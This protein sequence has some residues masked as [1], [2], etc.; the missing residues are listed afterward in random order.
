MLNPRFIQERKP[1]IAIVGPTAIGKSRVAIE[2]AKALKTEVLTADSRQVYLGMDIGTDKPTEDER[3]GVP[4]RLIDLV[5]PDR[6]FTA[7]DYR[8]QARIE[9]ARL[10]REGRIPLVA[11]G[12]GL[13]IRVLFRGLCSG[14]PADWSVRQRLIREAEQQ[15]WE[16]L[17][18]QLACVD[19][20]L[21]RQLH[22]HDHV[23][24]QR[25]LEVYQLT[26]RP[27]S[28]AHRDHGFQD[29]AYSVLMIG[30]T[31]PRP[32]L[33]ARIEE[34]VERELG[35]GLVEETR[36]LLSKGY[37]RELPSM[38][39]LGYRQIAGFLHGEYSY[40]EA[41]RRLKRDTRHFA[42]RQYTWFRKEPAMRWMS[43]GADETPQ[44]IAGRILE[45]VERFVRTDDTRPSIPNGPQPLTPTMPHAF[46]LDS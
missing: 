13:Y 2:V 11:G 4:H 21:A 30:L 7:G 43:I 8:Q 33:Y 16:F 39:S 27:L 6:H 29:F 32:E 42:K 9:I 28:E 15:G 35:K 34:R 24:I 17:Y 25:A 22:P 46:T 3:Q 41:V 10:H 40:D 36:Q 20:V 31:M 1:V 18:R 45:H 14:P 26:G 5:E 37:H 12:T 44:Q 23:K 19:P 38:K